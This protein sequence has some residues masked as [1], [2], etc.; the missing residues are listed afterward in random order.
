MMAN[1]LKKGLLLVLSVTA[2]GLAGCDDI[3]AGLTDEEKAQKILNIEADLTGNSI[4]KLY[5]SLVPGGDTSA[6][7]LLNKLLYAYAEN[8]FGAFYGDGGLLSVGEDA[9]LAETYKAKHDA[10]KTK[11]EVLDFVE[12]VKKAVNKTFFDAISNSSYQERSLFYEE[13]FYRSQT[14][15]LYELVDANDNFKKGVAVE[16]KY[17]V[18]TFPIDNYFTDVYNRY[19]DYI[20]RNLLPNIYRRALIKDYLIAN[21]YGALGRSY[22]RK[23]Q[24]IA[25]PDISSSASATQNLVR[26]FCKLSLSADGIDN[27]KR[28]LR[29]LDALYAGT[30]NP[31]EDAFAAAIYA[32]AGWN[33]A[34][35]YADEA[36]TTRVNESNVPV[37][38]LMGAIVKDYNELETDRNKTGSGT[39]F[40]SGGAYTKEIGLDLK[41]LDVI[42]G[43]RVTEG[44]Y[45]SSSLSG[46]LSSIKDRLFKITVANEVDNANLIDENGDEKIRSRTNAFG[47]YVKGSYYMVPET[48]EKTEKY[49]YAIYDKSSSTWYICRVDQ[50]VKSSKL[51]PD[52]ED[53][54]YDAATIGKGFGE[55]VDLNQVAWAVSELLADTESY[56]NAANQSVVKELALAYHDQD[57]YD[58]FEKTFPDLFD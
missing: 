51:S 29:Y 53:S 55:K 16:G 48:F 46:L 58:Y 30:I 5:D 41:E 20:E 50:A 52:R 2:L 39:D 12:M 8:R 43:S 37:E 9:S 11:E 4:E 49:P 26:S 45:T 3:E 15:S 25:L 31:A 17:T 38:T 28:D 56:K 42:K 54:N 7:R 40:T 35:G 44:W 34:N 1:K 57:V 6:E 22:A 36:G 33:T 23:V 32:D 13:L 47:Y 19:A 21:N 24:F 18:E 27:S 14:K 10:F